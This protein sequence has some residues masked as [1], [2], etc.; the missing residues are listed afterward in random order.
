MVAVYRERSDII[1]DD[2]DVITRPTREWK[3]LDT[4]GSPDEKTQ[5][6]DP[7]KRAELSMKILLNTAVQ[8]KE[9]STF[10]LN[11][12]RGNRLYLLMKIHEQIKLIKSTL[13]NYEKYPF[14]EAELKTIYS[15]FLLDMQDTEGSFDFEKRRIMQYYINAY[16]QELG[17]QMN[18]QITDPGNEVVV[19]TKSF[20]D[21]VQMFAPGLDQLPEIY[22]QK[23]ENIQLFARAALYLTRL[24]DSLFAAF[25]RMLLSQAN[26]IVGHIEAPR[27]QLEVTKPKEG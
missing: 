20:A 8:N 18:L 23:P 5:E 7:S 13:F 15:N 16:G 24:D 27:R 1:E 2:P 21:Q 26:S 10:N 19:E 11:M 17:I 9:D 14:L 3:G 6:F 22:L 25:G 4:A 12:D